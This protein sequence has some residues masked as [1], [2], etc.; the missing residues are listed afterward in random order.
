M[1]DK[2]NFSDFVDIQSKLEIKTGKVTMVE[3]V[4]KSDKLLKLLVEFSEDDKRDVVTNIKTSL[5]EN[6]SEKLLNKSFLFVTNLEPV[7]MM[8]IESN[9]MI[10]PGEL[11]DGN[12]VEVN[13]NGE[14]IL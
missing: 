6:F 13:I 9:A 5:G 10:M 3:E 7:K 8:C 2:I 4:K 1:K 12:L 14:T 11:K